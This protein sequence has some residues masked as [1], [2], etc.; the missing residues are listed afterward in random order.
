[1]NSERLVSSCSRDQ[2]FPTCFSGSHL[3]TQPG[4]ISIGGKKII[5]VG[6]RIRFSG[7]SLHPWLAWRPVLPFSGMAEADGPDVII[8][9]GKCVGI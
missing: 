4:S 7:M 8:G 5:A 2:N 3:P 1:M 9:K 6:E